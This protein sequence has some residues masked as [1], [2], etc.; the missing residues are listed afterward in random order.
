[1]T[2]RFIDLYSRL[3]SP[4]HRLAAGAKAGAAFGVLLAAGLWPGWEVL[5]T[6]GIVVLAGVAAGRIPWGF[7]ISRWLGLML[8][9][10]PVSLLAFFQ[11]GGWRFFCLFL[12]RGGVC[13][14]AVLLLANT[15]PMAEILRVLR[16]VGMPGMMVDVLALTC[17]YLFVLADEAGRMRFARQS[18][19]FEGSR[20]LLWRNGASVI[21]QLFLRSL[22]RAE[23]VQAARLAR[24]GK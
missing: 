16:R 18:R 15:T 24:G 17:R 10:L 20:R 8:F 7:F 2:G 5:M 23:R 13:A 1:M 9:I 4:V 11:P 12:V 6:A 3:D 14:G 22:E 19:T 21:G